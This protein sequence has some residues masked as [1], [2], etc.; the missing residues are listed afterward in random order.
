MKRIVIALGILLTLASSAYAVYELK[1]AKYEE[2]EEVYYSFQS[3]GNVDYKVFLRPNVMYEQEYLGK[4]R[5]YVLNYIDHVN[6]K[7]N[8]FFKGSKPA[9][10]EID[11]IVK[12]YLQGLHGRENEVLWSKDFVLVPQKVVRCADSEKAIEVAVPVFLSEYMALKEMI[13]QDSQVNTPVVLKV[14]FDLNALATTEKGARE[15]LMSS[16]IVIPIGENVFPIE[17][18][19]ATV[20]EGSLSE[21]FRVLRPVDTREVAISFALSFLFLAITVLAAIFIQAARPPDAFDKSVAAIFKEYGERLASLE[22]AIPNEHSDL[23]NI[24][25][26]GDMVKIA[27]EVG[28]PVFYYKV[29]TQMERKIEFYVFDNSRTYYMVIFGEI[30]S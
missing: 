8:Y 10:L 26:I 4:D 22:Q 9:D 28:Q 19:P 6:I 5:Y 3:R 17:Y 11:Y 23:I 30:E 29:N 24:N 12:A 1:V 20:G 21:L 14:V 15:D 13:F 25:S 27:D 7:F 2:K 16:N 18:A